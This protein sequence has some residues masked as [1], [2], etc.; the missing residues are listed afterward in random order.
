MSLSN[1]QRAILR[2]MAGGAE[3]NR[4]W[5]RCLNSDRCE[6]EGETVDLHTVTALHERRL[7]D[8]TIMGAVAVYTLT[9]AGA[10]AAREGA[11]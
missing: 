3:L 10:E 1:A 7:I 6:L 2:D 4:W 9:P 5:S 11:E 8:C